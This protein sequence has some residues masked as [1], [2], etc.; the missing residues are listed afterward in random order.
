MIVT[1]EELIGIASKLLCDIAARAISEVREFRIFLLREPEY[2]EY[3]DE[4]KEFF[5]IAETIAQHALN[6]K[7]THR[8]S[9]EFLLDVLS[10]IILYVEGREQRAASII[11][12]ELA[13]E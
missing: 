9:V 5:N 4:G 10:L 2:E 6:A 13:K 8:R 3:K 11:R 1:K 12:K 7:P